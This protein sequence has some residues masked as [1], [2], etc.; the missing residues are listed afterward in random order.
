MVKEKMKIKKVVGITDSA[1]TVREEVFV[2]EQGFVDEFDEIDRRATHIILYDKEERPIATCRI[3]T[4]DDPNAYIL[5]RLAVIKDYRGEGLGSYVVE[6]AEKCVCEKGGTSL[7]L[8]AQCRAKEFYQ[9]LGYQEYGPVEDDQ[10]CPHIWM[11]K[12]MTKTGENGI[13]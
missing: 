1:K 11:K 13:I 6:Q 8:H 12:R 10:G 3:F 7:S 4:E 2:K 5:G 9:K